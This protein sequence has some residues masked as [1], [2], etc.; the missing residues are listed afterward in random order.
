MPPGFPDPRC[1][2]PEKTARALFREPGGAL[3]TL[4]GGAAAAR[5]HRCSRTPT[6]PFGDRFR[7]RPSGRVRSYGFCK[8]VFPRARLWTTRTSPIAGCAIGATARLDRVASTDDNHR[9]E[10]LVRGRG[11]PFLGAPRGDCSSRR[12]RPD[13]GYFRAPP[14]AAITLSPCPKRRGERGMPPPYG[15]NAGR[16]GAL[17]GRARMR[18]V[19]HPVSAKKPGAHQ[20]EA[21][22]IERSFASER[23]R[24]PA[25]KLERRATPTPFSLP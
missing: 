22:S 12:L 24:L 17:A 15:T 21:P 11:T 4:A 14:V 23:R 10:L 6:R 2:P 1:L 9:N 3:P 8:S 20:P 5:F 25:S 13:P 18:A 19:R 7:E 16:R